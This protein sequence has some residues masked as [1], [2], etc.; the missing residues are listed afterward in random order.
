M[1]TLLLARHA[2]S[3]W[4]NSA[5]S[6]HDRPLSLRGERDAPRMGKR[7]ISG[8]VKPDILISSPALRAYSTA[9]KIAAEIGYPKD[10]ILVKAKLYFEGTAGMLDVIHS[11]KP[12]ADIAMLFGHNPTITEL[13]NA[14]AQTTIG[15]VPTCGIAEIQFDIES[16]E[17]VHEGLGTMQLFDYPKRVDD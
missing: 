2:K 15:N 7:L 4:E 3:N 8:G 12:K 10:D 14:L 17:D 11:L 16:W 9:V 6:D 13:V 5:L 1:K